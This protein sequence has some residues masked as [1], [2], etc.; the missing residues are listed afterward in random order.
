MA[1]EATLLQ[2]LAAGREWKWSTNYLVDTLRLV[3][4]ND[5]PNIDYEK[6]DAGVVLLPILKYSCEPLLIPLV[7]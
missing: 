7:P 1:S 5:P 3:L 4:I 6:H 2:F